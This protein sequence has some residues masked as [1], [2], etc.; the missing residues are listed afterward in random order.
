M[1]VRGYDRLK[2]TTL[3]KK[4]RWILISSQVSA[5]CVH[6]LEKFKICR[7]IRGQSGHLCW[8]INLK[9]T[10]LTCKGR[11]WHAFCQVNSKFR[12]SNAEKLKISQP[13]QRPRRPSLLMDRINIGISE[14]LISLNWRQTR[15]YRG[16]FEVKSRKSRSKFGKIGLNNRSF[17]TKTRQRKVWHPLPRG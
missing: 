4:K 12:S 16:M 2:I 8:W 15:K 11:W 13:N 9:N 10:E 5:K 7:Q 3:L 6:Q 1:I 17:H 14:S